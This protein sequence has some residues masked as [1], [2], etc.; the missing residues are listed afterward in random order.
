MAYTSRYEQKNAI[1]NLGTLFYILVA[2]AFA[3]FILLLLFF[4]QKY[5]R[6]YQLQLTSVG[7]AS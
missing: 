7:C 3:P 1:Q 5:S 6:V 2:L 4:L